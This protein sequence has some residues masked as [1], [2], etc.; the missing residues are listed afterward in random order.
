MNYC[1]IIWGGAAKVHLEK[2]LKLQKRA[3]RIITGSGY[4][5]HTAPLFKQLELLKVDEIYRVSCCIYELKNT[6]LFQNKQ[7]VRNTRRAGFIK[8]G[9]QRLSV[10]QR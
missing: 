6:N 8:V 9:F 10:Y 4:L 5:E 1:N 2:L 3:V 7:N